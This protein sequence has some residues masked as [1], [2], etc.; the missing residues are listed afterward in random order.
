MITLLS[1]WASKG[2]K[3][4]LECVQADHRG[5]MERAAIITAL[6]GF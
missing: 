3:L 6:N 2:P 5:E 4:R 1:W